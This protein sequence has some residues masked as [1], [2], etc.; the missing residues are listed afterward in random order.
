MRVSY[1]MNGILIQNKDI[2]DLIVYMTLRM[3][4]KP[5][6]HSIVEWFLGSTADG[7]PIGTGAQRR[8]YFVYRYN[9]MSHVGRISTLV[10]ERRPKPI[11]FATMD[12]RIGLRRGEAFEEEGACARSELWPCWG[13]EAESNSSYRISETC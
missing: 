3:W 5:C 12:S 9:L 2:P 4:L 8:P 6:D 7:I 10:K 11:C 13:D 1:G